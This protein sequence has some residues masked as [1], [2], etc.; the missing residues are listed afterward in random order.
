MA[1]KSPTSPENTPEPARAQLHTTCTST[2]TYR[3]PVHVVHVVHNSVCTRLCTPCARPVHACARRGEGKLCTSCA[4]RIEV[5]R[6]GREGTQRLAAWYDDNG[7][8][9]RGPHGAHVLPTLRQAGEPMTIRDL[10]PEMLV[11]RA[12]DPADQKLV[13]LM[14]RHIGVA[15]RCQRDSGTVRS[16]P[17]KAASLWCRDHGVAAGPLPAVRAVAGCMVQLAS[18]VPLHFAGPAF[19]A[20]QPEP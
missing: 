16:G 18:A 10:A 11:P 8:S 4:R 20:G 17:T 7:Y 3:C 5:A 9:E 19:W 12:L 1:I 14:T 13:K 6:L 15:L 2:G